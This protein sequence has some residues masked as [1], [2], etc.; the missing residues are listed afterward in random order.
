MTPD[1]D[2]LVGTGD[3][4]AAL[5][6][7]LVHADPEPE[8]LS[9]H[10]VF[11][12]VGPENVTVTATDGMSAALAIVSVHSNNSGVL[13]KIGLIP[14]DVK[15]ILQ[16]HQA[17][18]KQGEDEPQ[19][20]LHLKVDGT[21]SAGSDEAVNGQAHLVITDESGMFPGRALRIPLVPQDDKPINI[22]GLIAGL[23]YGEPAWSEGTAFPGTTV[24]R[25]AVAAKAYQAPIQITSVARS[26]SLMIRIG[27]SFLG[28]LMPIS[29][30]EAESAQQTRW[31]ADWDARLPLPSFTIVKDGD[32]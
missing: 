32:E 6:S 30:H 4:R 20:V 9:R 19:F 17:G 21:G 24:A 29:V 26:R 22:T 7:V 14:A 2:L 12:D 13:G 25:F 23:H 3:L 11:L 1:L 18:R 15:K 28:A 16:I 27:E 31:N 8:I 10:Q 5:A